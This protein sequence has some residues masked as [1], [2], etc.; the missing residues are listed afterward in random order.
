ML[1]NDA[2]SV[3]A[4][5][6][7]PALLG[8]EVRQGWPEVADFNDNVMKVGLAGDSLHYRDQE[9]TLLRHGRPEQI[10]MDLDYSP[11]LDEAGDPAGVICIL[12]ET[13]ER[14]EAQRHASFLLS[15]S[16]ALRS[17][18]DPS[19]ILA[20]AAKDLGAELGASRVFYATISTAGL[21]TVEHDHADGVASIVG[22]HSLVSFGPDS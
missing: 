20:L 18:D 6:R 14:V 16:D 5:G 4:G 9:L 2:Y 12:G 8:A 7:H 17:L 3:F 21:M 1:Y 10:W 11:V 19:A 13:T 22:E 15:L